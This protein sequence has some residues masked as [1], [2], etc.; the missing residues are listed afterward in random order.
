M[1]LQLGAQSPLLSS[2]SGVLR[3]SI[4]GGYLAV[5]GIK[6]V[7]IL[8]AADLSLVATIVPSALVESWIAPRALD[9]AWLPGA[10]LLAV[11]GPASSSGAFKLFALVS[12]ATWT[13]APELVSLQGPVAKPQWGYQRLAASTSN[14]SALVLYA[15]EP[16]GG[17]QLIATLPGALP[18]SKGSSI[19]SGLTSFA[20]QGRWLAFVPRPS[21]ASEEL[22]VVLIDAYKGG[23]VVWS[24]S[25]R[26]SSGADNPGVHHVAWADNGCGLSISITA[27]FLRRWHLGFK[28][29]RPGNCHTGHGCTTCPAYWHTNPRA[30]ESPSVRKANY[31]SERVSSLTGLPVKVQLNMKGP[32]P[33]I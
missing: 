9:C 14:G 2:C 23:R 18:V 24:Y 30:Q 32:L 16:A 25:L 15:H 27:G 11:W 10:R 33:G 19:W 12:T 7:T 20:W 22:S 6:E 8:R 5:P 1:C 13:A 3:W 26:G 17:M 29:W 4:A 31:M 28:A 21:S